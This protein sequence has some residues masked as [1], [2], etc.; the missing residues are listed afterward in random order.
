MLYIAIVI[1]AWYIDKK[2]SYN[3]LFE[4]YSQDARGAE[5]CYMLLE[6]NSTLYEQESIR[7]SGESNH[8]FEPMPTTIDRLQHKIKND[9]TYGIDPFNLFNFKSQIYESELFNGALPDCNV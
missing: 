4:Y 7:Q 6:K 1:I 9:L 5:Y 2:P 8:H 3:I